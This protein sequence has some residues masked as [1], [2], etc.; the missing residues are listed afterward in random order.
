VPRQSLRVLLVH[1]HQ[2]LIRQ[3]DF[4]PDRQSGNGTDLKFGVVDGLPKR[5][6]VQDVGDSSATL[7]VRERDVALAGCTDSGPGSGFQF[8]HLAMSGSS[9]GR[10]ERERVVH[11]VLGGEVLDIPHVVSTG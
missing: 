6:L 8:R 7:A 1:A 9:N 4:D 3:K 10:H 5:H 2:H 11:D